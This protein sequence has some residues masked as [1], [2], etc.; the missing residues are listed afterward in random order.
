MV[1]TRAKLTVAF[2]AGMIA[3][4]ITLFLAVLTAR[5]NAVYHDIAQYSAAQGDLAARVITEA[6]QSGQKVLANGDTALIP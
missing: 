1:S 4:A 3:V 5:N 2:V 6:A